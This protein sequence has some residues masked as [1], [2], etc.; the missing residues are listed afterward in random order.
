MTMITIMWVC[1][2]KGVIGAANNDDD[3]NGGHDGAVDQGCCF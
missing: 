3:D 2:L 1:M